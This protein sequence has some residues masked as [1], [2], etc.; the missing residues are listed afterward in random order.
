MADIVTDGRVIMGVG[1]GYHTRE[2]ESFGAPLL[3]NGGQ[4]RAVRGADGRAAQV[5]QRGVV[6][7]PRQALH[8]PAR[9]GLPRLRPAVKSPACRARSTGRSRSGSRSRAARRSSTWPRAASRRWSPSTAR[10]S[11]T[12]SRGPTA[13]PARATGGRQAARRGPLL[14]RRPLHRRHRA[15]RRSAASSRPT[16]SATSGSRRSASCATPTSRAARGARPARPRAL[17]T[18]REGVEQ[19]AWLVGPPAEVDRDASARSRRRYP[20][21]DQCMIHWAEGMPPAEFK[22]QLRWF[23]RD[24]MPAF[25]GRA[26][27]GRGGPPGGI[28]PPG[29]LSLVETP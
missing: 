12:R 14:G 4:Q 29:S 17:P 3:D 22:E 5:L 13:T 23:A 25:A 28:P 7:P 1:R 10:R 16:T 15:R 2:V 8:D 18:L 27:R 11:S 19:K 26:L 24:V 6:E 9:R 21:L 20:G